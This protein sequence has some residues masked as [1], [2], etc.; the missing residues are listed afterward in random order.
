MSKHFSTPVVRH[1]RIGESSR[2]SPRK[3]E[4][5]DYACGSSRSSHARIHSRVNLEVFSQPGIQFSNLPSLTTHGLPAAILTLKV[6]SE[7]PGFRRTRSSA[8]RKSAFSP[9]HELGHR[10]KRS[11]FL[12]GA[13]RGIRIQ[14][15]TDQLSAKFHLKSSHISACPPQHL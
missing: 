5:P 6:H 7:K 2:R 11:L 15:Y 1:S 13:Q 12:H 10:L 3:S 8:G 9:S 14:E 4:R